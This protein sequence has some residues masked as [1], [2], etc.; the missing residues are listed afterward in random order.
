MN[1]I[2]LYKTSDGSN[3]YTFCHGIDSYNLNVSEIRFLESI[4]YVVK[5]GGSK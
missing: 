5:L 3:L 1:T 4:G 2:T